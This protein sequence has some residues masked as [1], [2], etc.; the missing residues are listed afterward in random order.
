[1]DV[2]SGSQGIPAPSSASETAPPAVDPG[3]G[4]PSAAAAGAPAQAWTVPDGTSA[5]VINEILAE[6]G[7]H[8]A[9]TGQR[10]SVS[11]PEEGSF[12]L[13]RSLVV[14]VEVDVEAGSAQF[15]SAHDTAMVVNSKVGCTGGYT[16]AGGWTWSGGRFDASHRSPDAFAL[17]HC[18][19]ARI[20]GVTIWNTRL[21]GH[22]IE[23]N[24]SGGPPSPKQVDAM[25]AADFT[26]QVLDCHLRGV[27]ERRANDN[28]E[29]IQLDYSW[30]GATF[31]TFDD[32][33]VCNNVLVAGCTF[34]RSGPA[35]VSYSCGF[36]AHKFRVA[37]D[38]GEP[39]P[40]ALHSHIRI[41]GNT[42]LDIRPVD[43]ANQRGAVHL[44]GMTQ[45][46]VTENEFVRC[47]YGI[48]ME[49][50]ALPA[51]YG[52]PELFVHAGN[53][54][55]DCGS[56]R[57]TRWCLT[58]SVGGSRTPGGTHWRHVRFDRNT[59]TGTIPANQTAYLI[60]GADVEGLWVV[61]NRFWG[62]AGASPLVGRAGNRI[63]GVPADPP[64]DTSGMSLSGN[65]WSPSASGTGAVIA[66]S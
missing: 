48:T 39:A 49:P 42:F 47:S 4:A 32:G 31:G 7:E 12:L 55:R 66:N 24:S 1:M 51:H 10:A 57:N 50:I 58:D 64:G 35:A 40:V 20:R 44:L 22:G 34:D 13:D 28:D 33:T 15:T 21:K 41:Q 19:R 3:D 36:G 18:P 25:D 6:A 2:A 37:P 9:H 27:R 60:S 5:S 59:F 56:T 16:A 29:A 17:A 63:H 46:M 54:F 26:I 52:V 8:A 38:E 53:T 61:N 45:V 11:F 65:T 14:P 43:V 30:P 23:I 62:L